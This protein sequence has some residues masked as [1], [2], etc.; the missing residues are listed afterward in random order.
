[1]GCPTTTFATP[2]ADPDT[3]STRASLTITMTTVEPLKTAA[4]MLMVLKELYE[5][6]CSVRQFVMGLTES[7]SLSLTKPGTAPPTPSVQCLLS[8]P[9]QPSLQIDFYY[10]DHDHFSHHKDH[11][12]EYHCNQISA[13]VIIYSLQPSE[14]PLS[15]VSLQPAFC[16]GD[17]CN[18]QKYHYHH[19]NHA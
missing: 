7:L 15:R 10:H 4:K 17:H 13:M 18:H 19:H 2:P 5:P 14:E 8:R 3:K 16:Y 9:S 6:R 1:M 11:Y 12:R